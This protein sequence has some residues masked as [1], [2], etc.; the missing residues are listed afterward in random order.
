MNPRYEVER[1][2]NE[3]QIVRGRPVN[4]KT[5]PGMLKEIN[6]LP[7][8]ANTIKKRR[9]A[10]RDFYYK[11]SL[12]GLVMWE[13]SNLLVPARRGGANHILYLDGNQAEKILS[14]VERISKYHHLLK[15][16]RNNRLGLQETIEFMDIRTPSGKFV[17]WRYIT[18]QVAKWGRR[19][20]GMDISA[21]SL[22]K[23]P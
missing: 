18:T 8:A 11:G 1:G 20:L 7:I 22:K 21:M 23:R 15:N 19:F 10:L 12:D 2:L 14:N 4:G 6:S 9:S 13:K 3:K 16:Y 5:L 17:R